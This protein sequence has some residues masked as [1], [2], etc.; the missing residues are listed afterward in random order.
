MTQMMQFIGGDVGMIRYGMMGMMD[1]MVG[2]RS[3]SPK[4]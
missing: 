1:G 4:Q 2:M 3:A